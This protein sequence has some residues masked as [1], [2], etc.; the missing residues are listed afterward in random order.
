MKDQIQN[1]VSFVLAGLGF[2]ATIATVIS[3]IAALVH[4]VLGSNEKEPIKRKSHFKKALLWIL[5]PVG[6]IVLVLL[7]F[8][9]VSTLLK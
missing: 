8:A 9:L 3:P 1:I 6:I 5:I 2:L 7:S 4:L